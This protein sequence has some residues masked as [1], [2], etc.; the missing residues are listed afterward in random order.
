MDNP[1]A[2]LRKFLMTCN[3]IKLN[4]V[5]VDAIQLR[6][7]PFSLRDRASDW[8]QNEEPNSF[9]TWETL[10]KVFLMKYFSPG[11]TAKLRNDITSFAQQ[12]G[13]SLYEAWERFKDLQRQCLHHGV[14]GW[15]LVQTFY[16][17]S[18]QSVKI[19]AD[20][21]TGGAFMGKLIKA[22]KVLLEEMASN[23]YRWVSDR[24]TLQRSG[25]KYVIDTV[26]LLASRVD[27]LA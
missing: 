11:K 2:H 25:S 14:P 1:N 13:E 6:H 27:S 16:N 19:L 5:S 15:L 12:D 26:T 21:A 9:T 22:A 20:A 4:G 10:S 18:E 17:G 24:A 23:N 8:L 7:F 3:T